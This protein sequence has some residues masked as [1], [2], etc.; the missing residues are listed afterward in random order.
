[1]KFSGDSFDL[2]YEILDKANGY[3][4]QAKES[5]SSPDQIDVIKCERLMDKVRNAKD[6]NH[7]VTLNSKD[8]CFLGKFISAAT[9]YD[10]AFE[11]EKQKQLF[12][13]RQLL[14]K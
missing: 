7:S 12:E 14:V 2:V 9:A 6:D 3:Y 1:M 11:N 5:G 8:V 10:T 13:L 4:K